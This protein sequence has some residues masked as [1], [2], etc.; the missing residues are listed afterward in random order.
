MTDTTE[1]TPR[2]GT[3]AEPSL[4]GDDV[5]DLVLIAAVAAN[6]VI[7][8]DGEIPWDFPADLRRFKRLTTGHPVIMGR[9]TYESIAADLGGP[10]PDRTNIVLSNSRP[11]LPDGVV[12]AA[13]ITEAIEAARSTG[14]DTAFVIGGAEVYDAFLPLASRMHLTEIHDPYDGDTFFPDFDRDA[15]DIIDR[16]PR[17]AF[18]FVTYERV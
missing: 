12:L 1:H 15:W 5:P 14:A 11:D 16:E 10:L 13:S 9:C 7:G 4:G 18:D 8:R 17:D 3:E 2:S 6:G